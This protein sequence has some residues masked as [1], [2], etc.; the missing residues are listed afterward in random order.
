MVQILSG[1]LLQYR[2]R[3]YTPER[4]ERANSKNSVYLFDLHNPDFQNKTIWSIADAGFR[5]KQ[6]IFSIIRSLQHYVGHRPWDRRQILFMEGVDVIAA[7]IA[8]L[9][10]NRTDWM[11]LDLVLGLWFVR[12]ERRVRLPHSGLSAAE[13]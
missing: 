2:A 3:I 13:H 9:Y 6:Q 10:H 12:V 4:V 11:G 1:E 7:L 8:D 5:G